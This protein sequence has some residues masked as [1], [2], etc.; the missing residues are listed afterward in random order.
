MIRGKGYRKRPYDKLEQWMD[1]EISFPSVPRS[2]LV[3]SPII[4]EELIE[5]FKVRR[6][7]VDGGS[8]S[9]VMI[10]EAQWPASEGRVTHPRM[11]ASDPKEPSVEEGMKVQRKQFLNERHLKEAELL[12]I[13]EEG[14]ILDKG[15]REKISWPKLL[16]KISLQKRHADAFDWV[17]TD[18][19]GIPHFVV[20]HE[21]KTYHHIEPRVQRKRSI[22]SDRRK[23]VKEEA[24]V[25]DMVIKSKTEPNLI[26]DI[27]ETL[28]T[29]KKGKPRKDK[30]HN[31]HAFP[32]QPKANVKPKWQACRI[33][34]EMKKL[35]AEMPTLTASRKDEELMVYLS[36]ANEANSNSYLRD[37]LGKDMYYPLTFVKPIRVSL[38][39][40]RNPKAQYCIRHGA[41]HK[42]QQRC[43]LNQLL[44]STIIPILK[45]E[46]YDIW[47][48]EMEH[49]LEYIDNEVWKV[50]QNGNSKKRISTGKDGI[51]RVLSP[52]TAAE[53]QAVEKERKAKNILLMAIPKEHMRRFHG[54]DV[55][56][57]MVK[58]SN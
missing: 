33:K 31:K 34:Q 29:L 35:I 47:A 27:E 7:Y 10:E 21:L 54:M 11:R 25:D 28:L 42:Q 38:V 30:C 57:D 48:M 13:P 12:P 4:P 6:I 32:K 49:Y 23:V 20:E 58:P 3:N 26:K 15:P 2:Q 40:K 51:V 53:I 14:T 45:K 55:K 19:T 8:S 50:I 17:P 52:V 5:G 44:F 16:Q 22:N 46:E 37:I 18:T 39:Y 9:E 43:I 56:R 36:T 1:N 24:Y 41:A